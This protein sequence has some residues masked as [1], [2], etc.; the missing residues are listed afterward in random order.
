MEETFIDVKDIRDFFDGPW[1]PK[2]ILERTQLR[3][4]GAVRD[5]ER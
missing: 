2:S 4:W 5:G 3:S 1:G